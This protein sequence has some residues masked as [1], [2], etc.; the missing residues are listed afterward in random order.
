MKNIFCVVCIFLSVLIYD[1]T[2][3]A[4]VQYDGSLNAI[5]VNGL[6][7]GSLGTY[8]IDFM[9]GMYSGIYDGPYDFINQDDAKDA[10]VAINEALNGDSVSIIYDD[11]NNHFTGYFLIPFTVVSSDHSYAR[12]GMYSSTESN[13]VPLP[14]DMYISSTTSHMYAKA[15]PVPIPAA[16][17]LLGSGLIG[18]VGV[19]KKFKQ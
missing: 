2:E 13:W 16:V 10:V 5:G 17:W 7:L 9:Y 18:I 6:D 14:G 19:R 1:Q 11:L 15:S 3:A 4:T 12:E 8:N